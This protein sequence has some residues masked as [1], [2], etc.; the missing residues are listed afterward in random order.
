MVDR[1]PQLLKYLPESAVVIEEEHKGLTDHETKQ[2]PHDPAT[3]L[4]GCQPGKQWVLGLR[5][6]A[7]TKY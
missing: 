4:G 6:E 2:V 3:D 1:A 5:P 7:G